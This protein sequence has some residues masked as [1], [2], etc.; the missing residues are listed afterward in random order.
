M[1]VFIPDLQLGIFSQ[2][3]K[4]AQVF[5]TEAKEEQEKQLAK[6]EENDE[7]RKDIHKL[8]CELSLSQSVCDSIE[9]W[10]KDGDASSP[11]C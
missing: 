9:K 11:I 4:M 2:R 7:L 1:Q 6:V 8:M 10:I 5:P 3:K